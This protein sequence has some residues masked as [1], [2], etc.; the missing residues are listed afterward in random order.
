MSIRKRAWMNKRTG[1]TQEKW[2]VDYVD[3]NGKRRLKTCKSKKDAEAYYVKTVSAIN[4]GSFIPDRDTITVREAGELWLLTCAEDN[5]EETTI[6]RYKAT[7]EYYLYPYFGNTKLTKLTIA[8]VSEFKSH[9]LKTPYPSDYVVERLRGKIPSTDAIRRSVVALGALLADAQLRGKVGKNI[10]YEMSR[11][12]KT[13]A[14]GDTRAK[15]KLI[16]GQD[17]PTN[18]E[19]A[20]IISCATKYKELIIT[21]AFTGLRASEIRGLRWSAVDIDRALIHVRQRADA[22]KKM[23]NTKTLS[24]Q[25]SIPIPPIVLNVLRTWKSVC[26]HSDLDFV[27]PTT[28]GKIEG[29]S[30]IVRR[31]FHRAQYAAGLVVD[32]G[33]RDK[34]G[35]PI[36][37]P[38]YTGLH[39]LRHWYASWCIN[40]RSAGGLE[41]L[42]KIVQERLGHAS[43]KITMDRYGHLFPRGDESKEMAH[44]EQAVFAMINTSSGPV[45][46]GTNKEDSSD[47]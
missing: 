13:K 4:D 5:L 20:A 9:L 40:P 21:D 43:I 32:T 25:R 45:S 39:T 14:R 3:Q 19:V 7:L 16:V 46:E 26:P 47:K 27:F 41:L 15:P 28:R 2:V 34:D 44:A 37:R 31:G 23:G 11:G 12:K 10:V 1:E 29:L 36:L 6:E 42:P 8:M 17:I 35:Q 18:E 30:N 33:E 38:K 22:K 24:G